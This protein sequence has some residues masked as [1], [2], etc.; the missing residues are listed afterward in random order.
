MSRMPPKAVV[1][2]KRTVPTDA[3]VLEISSDEDESP[4][5]SIPE[6]IRK[7]LAK[8][9][10]LQKVCATRLGHSLSLNLRPGSRETQESSCL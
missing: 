5:L 1:K 3:E 7:Q 8:Y 10:K 2:R 9:E 6:P 4:P